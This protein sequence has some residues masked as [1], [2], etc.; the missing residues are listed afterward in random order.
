MGRTRMPRSG[1]RRA[2]VAP[3]PGEGREGGQGISAQGVRHRSAGSGARAWELA[4]GVGGRLGVRRYAGPMRVHP[5]GS[6][7]YV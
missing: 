2:R 6:I 7:L 4:T 3:G 5:H 1:R